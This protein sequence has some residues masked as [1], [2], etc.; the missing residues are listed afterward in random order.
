MELRELRSFSSVAKLRS[1][2]KA[3]E[4]LGSSQPTVTLQIQR[5]EKELGVVLFDRIKRPI[6][7]TAAGTA[8]AEIVGPLLDTVDSLATKAS[9]LEEESPVRIA[10]TPDLIPHT[11]LQVVKA[12]LSRYPN[13]HLRIRSE[14]R[15][16]VSWLVS[17]GEVDIG[18]V[19]G[20][21]LGSEFEF[22]G[23]FGYERVLITPRNHP[24]LREPLTDL[25]Q[26]AKYPLI[27]MRR[28]TYSRGVLE[29]EFQRHGLQ[30]EIILELDSMDMI[31]RY[32]ALGLGISIGPRLAIEPEDN[33][34]LE[35]VALTMLLPVEQ[36]GLIT[37]RGKTLSSSVRNFLAV[38]RESLQQM[39]GA[40]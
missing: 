17:E 28:G 27:L 16:D 30:Y 1:I 8:F 7:V 19:P 2:S 3:A 12:F 6:Q 32:V 25:R 15:G 18:F 5:L 10:S 20:P 11:L 26:I 21:E 23:L 39:G 4:Q 9:K 34:Q 14:Q 13:I 40:I 35:V 36:A 29:E 37:L 24:L 33:S 38:V 22:E 31:K